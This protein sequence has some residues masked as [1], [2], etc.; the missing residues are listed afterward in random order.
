MR[1]HAVAP[2]E[3]EVERI[4]PA[5]ARVVILDLAHAHEI[6]FAALRALAV[7]QQQRIEAAVVG[8][9]TECCH[10]ATV[11][12]SVFPAVQ[13]LLL[14]ATGRA[15][16]AALAAGGMDAWTSEDFKTQPTADPDEDTELGRF[17][18]LG[19]ALGRGAV[20]WGC[21]SARIHIACSD[22]PLT[23][24]LQPRPIRE[25]E[26]LM[27]R[28]LDITPRAPIDDWW[29]CTLISRPISGFGTSQV[30]TEYG[31]PIFPHP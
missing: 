13:N 16:V 2:F 4:V 5:S 1:L 18:L 24:I 10:P 17:V 22:E 26:V 14:A 3:E 19:G 23:W 29:E 25:N 11:G 9:D 6:R 15:A 28:A 31:K 8:A 20:A 30:C 7:T 12:S 21:F 27:L